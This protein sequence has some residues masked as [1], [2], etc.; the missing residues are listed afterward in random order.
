MTDKRKDEMPDNIVADSNEKSGKYFLSY[1]TKEQYELCVA[2]LTRAASTPSSKAP[3][4]RS[5]CLKIRH[6]SVRKN[7]DGSYGYCSSGMMP[8]AEFLKAIKPQMED[9][10]TPSAEI[11]ALR[12]IREIYC[13][14]EGFI[15][16][17]APEAYVLQEIK[18]MYDTAVEALNHTGGK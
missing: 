2:A 7:D 3:L 9:A 15:P 1:M 13:N 5:E 4:P 14:M 8:D 18:K 16:E 12:E 10:S 6:I 11:R 17:T